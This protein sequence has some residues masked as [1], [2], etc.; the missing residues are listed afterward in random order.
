[1]MLA[2]V[3]AAQGAAATS[4]P[5]RE[6]TA[7][8]EGHAFVLRAGDV[9][10]GAD[11][12]N[13]RIADAGLRLVRLDRIVDVT[14]V[15]D[16]R[17]TFADEQ[18]RPQLVLDVA[19]AS[20]RPATVPVELGW[21]EHGFRWAPSY[22]VELD[23]DGKAVLRLETTLVADLADLTD[24]TV[25]LVVGVPSFVGKD[26]LDPM[27][28]QEGVAQAMVQLPSGLSQHAFSNA[29]RSQVAYTGNFAAAS[30]AGGDDAG[31]GRRRRRRR[32]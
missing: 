10:L 23:G 17:R 13:A 28:L 29:M 32:R 22:R 7:F 27:A 2:A 21:V 14:F 26:Q 16:C 12:R 19:C 11:G 31:A 30:P 6:V 3:A 20:E 24:A 9:P 5:I 4:L 15:D 1:M 18:L 8:K 25:H